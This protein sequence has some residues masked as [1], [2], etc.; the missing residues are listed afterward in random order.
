MKK[1]ISLTLALAFVC[2]AL[3]SCSKHTSYNYDL[4]DYITLAEYKNLPA[5]AENPAVSDELFDITV[6]SVINAY[7]RLVEITDRPIQIGDVVTISYSALFE[8]VSHIPI[9]KE[10]LELTIGLTDLPEEFE[11]A[12]IGMKKGETTQVTATLP[13]DFDENPDYVGKTGVFDIYVSL[14]C[15]REAPVYNDDFARA[16]LKHDSVEEYESYVRETLEAE[17]KQAYNKDVLG[18]VWQTIV[19]NT[20]VVKYPDAE[21]KNYYDMTINSV[22]E[23]VDALGAD[24]DA[25][26]EKN[27]GMTVDEFYADALA[28]SQAKV[29]E[30]MIVNQIARREGIKVSN[31]EYK[32]RAEEYAID[33]YGLES[34]EEF[35]EMFSREEIEQLILSDLVREYVVKVS[36][37]QISD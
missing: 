17:R 9:V 16:Y 10:N 30:E 11:N 28:Q 13:D 14:V 18:Q 35:E 22:K 34:L 32:K 25:F 21:V 29:K 23:Y 20:E 7:S 26:V 12:L 6:M 8:E 19:D 24:F 36:D 3:F 37:V 4:D 2:I 27:F 31:E 15:E 33:F 1:I 5:K